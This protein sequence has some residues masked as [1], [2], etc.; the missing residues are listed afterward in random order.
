MKKCQTVWQ[1]RTNFKEEL[2]IYFLETILHIVNGS[3]DEGIAIGHKAKHYTH[4]PMYQ[5]RLI[6]IFP[7]HF[8]QLTTKHSFQLRWLDVDGDEE[9]WMLICFIRPN[10]QSI[11]KAVKGNESFFFSLMV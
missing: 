3:F 5:K 4:I 10:A 8:H 2:N 9:I 11:N 1:T 6:Y 7:C